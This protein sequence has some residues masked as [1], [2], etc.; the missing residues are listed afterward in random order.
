MGTGPTTVPA[1]FA[2]A[3]AVADVRHPVPAVHAPVDGLGQMLGS[4]TSHTLSSHQPPPC[5][6]R[7]W[8]CIGSGTTPTTW[9]EGVLRPRGVRSR[10][11]GW[12]GQVRADVLSGHW[13]KLLA[14]RVGS[15]TLLD[16]AHG[17]DARSHRG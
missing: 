6:E 10:N 5:P 4:A 8:V 7:M 15:N 12:L 17:I 16:E 2:F 14:P 1:C 3:S 11:A 13:A 9:P